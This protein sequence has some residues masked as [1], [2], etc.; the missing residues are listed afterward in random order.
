MV[1]LMERRFDLLKPFTGEERNFV[2]FEKKISW[3]P[4]VER[5]CTIYSLAGESFECFS[6]L[7][8]TRKIGFNITL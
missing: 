4:V 8:R 5:M 3:L 7:I 2:S 6:A 1:E